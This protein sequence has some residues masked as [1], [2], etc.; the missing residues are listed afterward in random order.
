MK[1]QSIASHSQA[2]VQMEGAQ[3][4][5]IRILIGPD[6]GAEN[7]HM[8]H[9]EIAPGGCTPHHQHDYEHEILCLAGKG[10]ARTTEGDKPIH[11]GDVAFVPANQMHQFRNES[12]Q[13]LEFI[14][15]IPAL[16]QC[17]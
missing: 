5:K 11:A 8:R 12:D 3:Q 10:V 7:F 2:P 14:C 1:I 16:E 6:D 17:K 13:P 9:F 4:A 15:L